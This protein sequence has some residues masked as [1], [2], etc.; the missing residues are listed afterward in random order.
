MPK[1]CWSIGMI[2]I[3]TNIVV[4]FKDDQMQFEKAGKSFSEVELFISEFPIA[5]F[6]KRNGYYDLRMVLLPQALQCPTK[7]AEFTQY[8]Y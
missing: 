1:V 7:I 4:C 3:D 8:L 6:L 2:A 5:L